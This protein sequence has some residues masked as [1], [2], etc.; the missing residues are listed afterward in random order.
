MESTHL[1]KKQKDFFVFF[2]RFCCEELRQPT[3]GEIAS[4]FGWDQ[5]APYFYFMPLVKKGYLRSPG[6][7]TYLITQAG[8]EYIQ[9]YNHTKDAETNLVIPPNFKV[10]TEAGESK[11]V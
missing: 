8:E 9:A 2:V 4:H 5:S 11:V 1:T 3:Y 10:N 7:G 6:H